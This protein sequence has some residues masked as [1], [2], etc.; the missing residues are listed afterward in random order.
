L[1]VVL[2]SVWVKLSTRSAD[3]PPRC[4]AGV[5]HGDAHQRA[6]RR[7]VQRTHSITTSP[8]SVNLIALVVRFETTWRRRDGSP[9]TRLANV[10]GTSQ[11]SSKPLSWA[12]GAS[13]SATSSATARRS[14]STCSIGILP[15][16]IFE[17]SRMSLITAS[18]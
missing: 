5:A 15:A 2:P 1:R 13:T 8:R 3:A 9:R 6:D 7:L 4:D 18:R 16:S 17:K 10:G 11:T 14:N 12:C